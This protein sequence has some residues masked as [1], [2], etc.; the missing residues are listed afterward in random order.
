MRSGV[1]RASFLAEGNTPDEKDRLIILAIDRSKKFDKKLLVYWCGTLV[2][3]VKV[4][5]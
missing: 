1:T 3:K 2:V 5:G 4:A